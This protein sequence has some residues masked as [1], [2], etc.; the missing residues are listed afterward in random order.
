MSKKIKVLGRRVLVLPDE[1]EEFSEGG[2]FIASLNRKEER[3]AQITGTVV[4]IGHLCWKG[5]ED[6]TPWCKVGDKVH[7]SR[8]AGRYIDDPE[9]EIRYMVMN[10][11]D[12]IALIE[13]EPNGSAE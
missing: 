12:I 7:F 9:T 6:E 1:V 8:Y 4:S 11:E 13:E 3:A 2:I 5:F 10:D